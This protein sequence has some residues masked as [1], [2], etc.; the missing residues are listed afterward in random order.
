MGVAMWAD[1]ASIRARLDA[2]LARLLAILRARS[3]IEQVWRFGSSL[4]GPVASTSDLDLLVVQRTTC[5]PVE[6]ALELRRALAP[7]V[8]VDLFV[9]TPDEVAHAGRFITEVLTH[10]RR[11]L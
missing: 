8:A 9:V 1:E 3:D 5:D 6:R 4:T 11:E 7:R 2:E 10:G